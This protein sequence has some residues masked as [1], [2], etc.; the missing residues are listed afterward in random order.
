MTRGRD[1]YFGDLFGSHAGDPS[2]S[3]LKFTETNFLSE[4]FPAEIPYTQGEITAVSFFPAQ[5]TATGQGELVIFTDRGA[6]SFD[7][8]LPRDQWKT[9]TFQQISLLNSSARGHRAVVMVNSDLWIRSDAGWRAY[10][11]ARSQAT[12][13]YQLPQSTEVTPWIKADTP[14]LLQFGSAIHFDNRLLVTSNP[15]P[16]SGR[17]YHNGLLVAGFLS[18]LSSFGQASRPAW[19]G[20]WGKLRILQLV[21]GTF[22]GQERAFA[23]G[24]DDD[25]QTQLFEISTQDSQDFDGPITSEIEFRSHN[26]NSPF[27]EK[28]L[29]GADI[30][31]DKVSQPVT[32][33][34]TFRADSGNDYLPWK[35]F[36][37]IRPAG[38]FCGE[39]NLRG[40]PD[41]GQWVCAPA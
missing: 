34:L 16:N 26:F 40:L 19:D 7:L 21:S 32:M 24:L 4:G 31:V 5:D 33:D 41:L 12:G 3:V 25:E 6:V 39:V 10:R 8:H 9:S 23:F 37:Q 22:K 36:K 38:G 20:H 15:V 29:Y 35:T 1:V 14:A 2:D 18:V 17:L 30:W 13:W 27:N 28:Q 11:Q